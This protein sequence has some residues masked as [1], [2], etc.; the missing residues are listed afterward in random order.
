M[1]STVTILFRSPLPE[2]LPV[3][4]N[5]ETCKINK[6]LPQCIVISVY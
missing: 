6:E 4:V 3:R 2:K 1:G 5:P